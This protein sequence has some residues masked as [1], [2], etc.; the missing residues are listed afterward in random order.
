MVN[1]TIATKSTCRYNCLMGT[2]YIVATPIGNLEDI[3]LRALRIL[4]EVDVIAC[5]DTRHTLRLLNHYKI[6]KKLIATHA[7]NEKNSAFGIVKLLKEGLNI[8]FVSDAG[9]PTVSDPGSILVS[10]VRKEGFDVVPIPGVSATTTLMSVAGLTGKTFTFEGFLPLKG[11]KRKN[12]L[13]ELLKR[14][15][16]FI[17][18]ES[19][20]RIIKLL[21][22]IATMEP[23]RKVIIGREMTK[24][25]EEF[26]EGRVEQLLAT[27][28]ERPAIKGEFALCIAPFSEI[29]NS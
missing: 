4:K 24:I 23:K 5:E 27:L 29:D 1:F 9:T 13:E 22:E 2:L 11:Q 25:Y 26:L 12:R 15:E 20:F 19:P 21:E 17:L 7:H 6:E 28:S 3:T 10:L 8:A 14:E 18:Y 16:A